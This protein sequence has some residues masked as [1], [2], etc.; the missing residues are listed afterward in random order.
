MT[1]K[2]N[3][4]ESGKYL[5]RELKSEYLGF[6]TE[7]VHSEDIE[8]M[9]YGPKVEA[10]IF[11]NHYLLEADYYDDLHYV[12]FGIEDLSVEE[13]KVKKRL[14]KEL[15]RLCSSNKY[16]P[17]IFKPTN[18]NYEIIYELGKDELKE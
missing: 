15:E 2:T 7:V 14:L 18:P 9:P 13:K 11:D 8:G 10:R 5:I 6:Y 16:I 3:K 1:N 12:L 17:S 4:Q